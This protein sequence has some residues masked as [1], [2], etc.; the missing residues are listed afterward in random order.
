MIFG[1]LVALRTQQGAPHRLIEAILMGR[2]MTGSHMIGS[3]PKQR[4][5][6]NK[7]VRTTAICPL[8]DIPQ[9]A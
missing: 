1:D 9:Q 4:G 7:Q 3:F 8:D 2:V 5:I 6:T